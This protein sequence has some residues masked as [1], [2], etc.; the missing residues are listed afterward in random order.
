MEA[1]INAKKE[2]NFYIHNLSFDIKPFL[3]SFI[4]EYQ[5]QHTEKVV[6]E[7]EWKNF[8]YK[9]LERFA[10]KHCHQIYAVA[11]AMIDQCVAAKI[12]PAKKYRVIYSGMDIEKFLNAVPEDNLR[13]QLGIPAGAKVIGSVARLFPLKGY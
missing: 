9:F 12:A 3:I 4:E 10:A 5:G 8:I 2:I 7:K 13:E 1:I 11:Q 6:Y